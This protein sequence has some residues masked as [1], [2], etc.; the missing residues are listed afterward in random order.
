MNQSC[1]AKG[2]LHEEVI[3]WRQ[4]ELADTQ[5][6]GQELAKHFGAKPAHH[7]A[8]RFPLSSPPNPS[9]ESVNRLTCAFHKCSERLIFFLGTEKPDL[10]KP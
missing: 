5:S 7:K 1:T 4:W 9:R 3:F 10:Q 6:I 8:E 2:L